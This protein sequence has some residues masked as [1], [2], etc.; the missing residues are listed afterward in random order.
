[1]LDPTIYENIKVVIEGAIYDLDLEGSLFVTRRSDQ[2]DLS[3]MSRSYVIQFKLRCGDKSTDCNDNEALNDPLSEVFAELRLHAGLKDL[4][5]EILEL[6]RGEQPGCQLEVV[7]ITNVTDVQK[8]CQFIQKALNEVWGTDVK[9]TQSISYTYMD[10]SQEQQELIPCRVEVTIDF[11]RK[12][13]ED[14]VEDI[15]SLMAHVMR[16]LEKLNQKDDI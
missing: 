14:Q 4:A 15:E 2:I 1:M 16:S 8:Q 11:N 9:I 12:I 13:N 6:K 7:F 10:A 5:S 3:S